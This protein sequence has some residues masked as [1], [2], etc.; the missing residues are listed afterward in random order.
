MPLGAKALEAIYA[1]LAM[2]K[3][4]S[5]IEPRGPVFVNRFGRRLTDRSI[6]RKLDGYLLAAGIDVH[7]SPHVLRHSFA[8][9]MLDAGA[10]LRSVQ[11]MLGHA[12]IATTQ[13]YTHVD[14]AR[15]RA[16]H[17]KFHPRG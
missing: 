5:G 16:I 7:I 14:A 1:Y 8:T 13:V 17:K 4:E 10:D 3:A 11:E 9:H 15:L 6:R 2:R 12:D